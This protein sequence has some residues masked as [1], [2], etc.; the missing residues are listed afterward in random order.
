MKERLSAE[1]DRF[2]RRFQRDA[3]QGRSER[4]V[5]TYASERERSRAPAGAGDRGNAIVEFVFLGILLMVPLVYVV[6]IAGALQRSA[7]AVTA[8]AR[9]AGRAYATAG[10]DAV[11]RDRAGAAARLVLDDQGVPVAGEPVSIRC[12]GPCD[13]A[14]GEVVTVDVKV[15]VGLPGVPRVFC[16]GGDCPLRP[17]IPVSA[18][19]VVRLDCYV[20][21]RKGAGC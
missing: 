18:S 13:Y 2:E 4:R 21:G 10:S 5:L 7:F 16:H 11:G 12:H 1:V 20:A 19:H 9:E 3:L 14:A 6:L 15:H 8:A 17:E